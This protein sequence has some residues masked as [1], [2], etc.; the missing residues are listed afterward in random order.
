MGEKVSKAVE[1]MGGAYSCSQSV[2][3]AFCEDAGI[4]HDDA[5]KIAAPYSGG[6]AIKCGALYA[7]EMV[8]KNKFGDDTN[9]V[10][11]MDKEFQEKVGA[12]NCRDIRGKN[13][14]PCI[15]CVEDSAT[16]LEKIIAAN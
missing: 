14:R 12:I 9:L 2:L 5:K 13:L 3:C 7:A 15:G 6:R 8:L 10:E 1:Y 11:E 16:I 4:S